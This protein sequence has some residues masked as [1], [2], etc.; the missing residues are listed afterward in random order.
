MVPFDAS[1]AVGEK[2]PG[3][4]VKSNQDEDQGKPSILKLISKTESFLANKGISWPWKGHEHDGNDA[5][6]QF[7]W[8][9]LHSD[10]ENDDHNL[11]AS[12]S[13]RKPDNQVTEN[14]HTCNISGTSSHNAN[15]TSSISS[16]CSTSS[17]TVQ[18]MDMDSDCLDYEILWE[19]L[20]IGEQIGQGKVLHLVIHL[21]NKSVKKACMLISMILFVDCNS[22]FLCLP[23]GC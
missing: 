12:E 11:E 19:D 20:T 2:S 22:S 8:P 10:Q 3:K 13:G 23:F 1:D 15:S 14:N 9:W 4:E 7:V 5:K 21:F 16:N 17:S 18:R 6:K